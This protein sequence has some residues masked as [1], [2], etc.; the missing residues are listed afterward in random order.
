MS[1]HLGKRVAGALVAV[2]TVAALFA[3]TAN[4]PGARAASGLPTL[5]DCATFAGAA[6]RAFF[7]GAR[8][9]WGQDPPQGGCIA[10]AQD[11]I[12]DSFGY[13]KWFSAFSTELRF[14]LSG[15]DMGWWPLTVDGDFGSNTRRAVQAYRRFE[16]LY[17]GASLNRKILNHMVRACQTARV[18]LRYETTACSVPRTGP[19][20]MP[21]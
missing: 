4:P 18:K 11:F 21:E 3:G 6:H 1:G 16:G 7:R 10:V 15:L 8:G 17:A 13:A 2:C 14:R 9:S 5:S 19:P 12:N 20:R